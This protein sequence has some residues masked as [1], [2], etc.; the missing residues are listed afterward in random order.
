MIRKSYYWKNVTEKMLK[1]LDFRYSNGFSTED[2]KA[3]IK[4][5]PLYTYSETIILEARIVAYLDGTVKVDVMDACFHSYYAAWYIEETE[6]RYPF[7]KE[8]NVKLS[9]ILKRYGI[10]EIVEKN[11]SKDKKVK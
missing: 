8:V 10:K 2:D 7:L 4:Y 6:E 5:V 11:G 3:F 9:K 1:Q